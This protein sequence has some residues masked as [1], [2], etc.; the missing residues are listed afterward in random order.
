MRTSPVYLVGAGPGDP[1]LITVRGHT[2]LTAADVIVYD[3]LANDALLK[4]ARPTAHLIFVGKKGFS[5][6]VT[7]AEINACLIEK[8][9]KDEHAVIVRLKGG[10]PFVFGRGGEEALALASEGIPFEVVPGVTAGVASPAYAGIPVTHRGVASSVTFVTGHETPEK[11]GSALNWKHLAHGADTLCFYMGVRNLPLI[12]SRLME[13]G[14]APETPVA[15][16]RWGSL[17]QQEVLASTLSQ[18]ADDARAADFQAPAIIVVGDVV[19]L[20]DELAWFERRPLHGKRVAVTRATT[21]ASDTVAQL[22]AEGADVFEFPTIRIEHL[23]V[24][25]RAARAI[26]ELPSYD[27]LVFTS[28]NGVDAF[29]ADLDARGLDARALGMVRIAAIGPATVTA[30]EGRHLHADLMPDRYVAEEAAA[31]LI[32]TGVHGKRVLIPRAEEAREI[33]PE[34]LR[35]AGAVTDVVAVYRT[36]ADDTAQAGEFATQ[37]QKG[38]I[39]AVTFTSSSTV[40]NCVELLANACGSESEARDLLNSTKLFSIGPITSATLAERGLRPT[41]EAETYTIDGLMAVLRKD[42]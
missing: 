3:Y 31:A 20:R 17:P 10:D 34:L 38:A 42:L 11:E 30:L 16:V 24:T 40:R 14:R 32:A 37:L 28:K 4:L 25:E 13:A 1:D 36:V 5:E 33:L 2:V 23:G 15:L 41:A 39:D 7:Q 12:T 8:A 9:T 6:H 26:D 27:W 18:A 21:Q 29:F 19:A 22:A 35:E